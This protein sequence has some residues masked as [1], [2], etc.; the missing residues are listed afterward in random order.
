[1]SSKVYKSIMLYQTGFKIESPAYR[2]MKG[3]KTGILVVFFLP[4]AKED[5]LYR[6]FIMLEWLDFILYLL[7][8][9]YKIGSSHL[10]IDLQ[11]LFE[12]SWRSNGLI[13]CTSYFNNK[14]NKFE[15]LICAKNLVYQYN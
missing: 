12:I 15:L 10:M 6:I 2:S 7:K 5:M 9:G 11:K 8:L 13:I 3:L 4:G 1:M 14:M